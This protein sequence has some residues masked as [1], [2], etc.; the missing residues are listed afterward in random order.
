MMLARMDGHV[1]GKGY[2]RAPSETL[3]RFAER[4]EN[5]EMPKPAA[6]YHSYV[7][8]RYQREIPREALERL[9]KHLETATREE[10]RR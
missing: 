5:A 9:E 4:L 10:T 2:T 7:E 3:N 6:W 1:A 8:V